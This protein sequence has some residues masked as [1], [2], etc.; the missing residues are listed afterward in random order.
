MR[1]RG[2]L[3]LTLICVS[4]GGC[5]SGGEPVRPSTWLDRL[6]S[7]R[8]ARGPDGIQIDLVLIQQPLGDPFLNEEVWKC[9]DCQAVGLERKGILDDNGFRV[10]QVVGMNPARLQSLLHCERHWTDNRKQT[11]AAG[12]STAMPLGPPLPQCSFQLKT[13]DGG[14]DVLLDQGQC[15]LKIDTSLASNGRTKLKFT[16]EV[17]YGTRMP[18][19]QVDPTAGRLQLEFKRP[20]KVYPELSWEVT[21]GP[22]QFLVI[23]S[24]FD[25]NGDE[26]TPQT[27]GSQFFI[28]DN[29]RTFVQRMLVLRTARG[30][31][32]DDD[33]VGAAAGAGAQREDGSKE[34]QPPPPVTPAA[35]CLVDTEP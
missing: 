32:G 19:Y 18:D 2:V 13:V 12:H 10:G 33:G 35:Q 6:R 9:T 11:L 5:L 24:H 26:N 34:A 17:L 21:L 15:V 7:P 14:I 3:V 30:G 20:S 28:Q 1:R 25:I 16:P 4:L 29:G 27:L 23:G 22:N 31:G 8:S